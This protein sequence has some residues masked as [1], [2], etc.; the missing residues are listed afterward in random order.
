MINYLSKFSTRLSELALPIRE[1]AKD[2]VAFN[3]GPEHQA[4]F[5]LV[6]IEIAV[7]PILAYY[8][9]KKT[10][11]LQTDVSINGHGVCLLQDEKPVYFA[12]KALTEA[13]HGYVAIELESLAVAW[14]M[15]KFHH[16]LY[17]NHFIL[18]TDQKPLETILSR[19]LNQ[20]MPRLQRI[21]IRTFP[22][23]FSVCYLPGLKNQLA[24]CLSRV[25]G[26]QDSIK[27]PKLSVYQITSQLNARSDSLQQLQ[28]ASQVPSQMQAFW[29][30]Q[31]ELTIEDGLISKG[32]RIVV[33]S[34][35]Q[36]EIHKLIHE[37][38]LGLTKCKLRAKETVYWPGLND[39]SEKLV[40]NC[41][42]CLKYL[43][44]KCKL[45]SNMSLGQEI[46][47]FPWTKLATNIFHFKGDYYLLLVDY[48][49]R[50]PIICKLTSMTAQHEIGHLKVIF[51]EYGWL[52]TIVSDNGPC[53]MAEAF[54]KIIQEYR[55]N[56]IT[57]SLHYPQSNGLAEKF[58]QTVKSLFY[59][60]REEGTDLYK[61]LMIY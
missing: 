28:E 52:D 6:K 53:Y 35:K 18:E 33:P 57:S 45:T 4:A 37:S 13:Q 48:T 34:M 15:E 2:K 50:Y 23:N 14:V 29:T 47:T 51:S 1:L 60:A 36:A 31:E 49:S 20:A 59:K 5:K 7:A 9:P 38:H 27:L 11:V 32:T 40:L 17:G 21:L 55:V 3:R 43:Q 26:L 42:L 24:D 16:F 25:G 56:H 39:Q 44:S 58:V 41:Q 30:F 54:T 22:Y 61:A 8:D 10:T 12:S 19:S 46:P